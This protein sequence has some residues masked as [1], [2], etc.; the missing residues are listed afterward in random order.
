MC[1]YQFQIHPK[2]RK[3]SAKFENPPMGW[4]IREGKVGVK[5]WNRWEMWKIQIHVLLEIPRILGFRSDISSVE[6][7]RNNGKSDCCHYSDGNNH[8]IEH[9]RVV[10]RISTD[11]RSLIFDDFFRYF[12]KFFKKF[13][14]LQRNTTSTN[15]FW[16]LHLTEKIYFKGR[17]NFLKGFLTAETFRTHW[18]DEIR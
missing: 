6:W 18:S 15:Y 4:I 1:C 3:N 16:H 5:K 14:Q 9:F 8:S 10:N 11:K 17:K 7:A 13:G 2:S 12:K